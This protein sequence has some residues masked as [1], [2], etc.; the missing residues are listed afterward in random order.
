MIM[1]LR[2]DSKGRRR[3]VGQE[4]GLRPL[5]PVLPAAWLSRAIRVSM[6]TARWTEFNGLVS[7]AASRA[8]TG[9]RA[10]GQVLMALMDASQ[11]GGRA[12]HWLDFEREK[13]QRLLGRAA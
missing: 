3:A 6:P 2:R 4:R 8:S 12:A 13:A 7:V 1:T 9:A 10:A 11:D 5:Y